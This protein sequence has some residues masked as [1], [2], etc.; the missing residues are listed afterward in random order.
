MKSQ[1]IKHSTVA[2]LLLSAYGASAAETSWNNIDPTALSSIQS[3]VDERKVLI[4]KINTNN[5]IINSID[6]R[7][8]AVDGQTS[9]SSNI[10]FSGTTLSEQ[11]AANVQ[12]TAA[13]QSMAENGASIASSAQNTA[14]AAQIVAESTQGNVSGIRSELTDILAVSIYR[15]YST[16]NNSGSISSIDAAALE[17]LRKYQIIGASETSWSTGRIRIE[18]FDRIYGPKDRDGRRSVTYWSDQDFIN[19]ACT[20]AKHYAR[21]YIGAPEKSAWITQADRKG[22]H[23]SRTAS[24]RAYTFKPNLNLDEVKALMIQYM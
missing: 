24:C 16:V 1:I 12:A 7:L 13:A 19:W 15:D 17:K 4:S 20:T 8:S 9:V 5:S 2:A 11:L 18:K 3:A 14:N 23:R 10:A 6:T 21:G 22:R